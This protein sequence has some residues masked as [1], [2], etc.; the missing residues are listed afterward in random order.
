MTEQ[1]KP[2]ARRAI[3][4]DNDDN[5]WY[6]VLHESSGGGI[7]GPFRTREEARADFRQAMEE[8]NGNQPK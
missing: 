8:R 2:I 7:A 3:Y 5:N 4:Q 6:W 1:T